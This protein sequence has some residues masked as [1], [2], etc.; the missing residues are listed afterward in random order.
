MTNFYKDF[1]PCPFSEQLGRLGPPSV[2]LK[3]N[4]PCVVHGE[5]A[6]SIVHQVPTHLFDQ[7]LLVPDDR[8]EAATHAICSVLPYTKS[9][10]DAE[11]AWKDY[12]SFNPKCPHAFNLHKSTM[13]LTHRDPTWAANNVCHI[14]LA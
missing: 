8:L 11:D 2:L 6:L 14:S 13:L 9:I 7:H 3:A 1:S 10:I 4:I 5:D 12:R